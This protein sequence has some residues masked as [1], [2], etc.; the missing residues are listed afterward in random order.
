MFSMLHPLDEIT[1]IVCKSGGLFGSRVQYVSDHTM[2]IVFT[3]ADPSIVMTYDTV[4]G[5]HTVWAL[6]KVKTEEQNAVL[7]YTDQLGTPQHG[8]MNSSLTAH[9]RSVSKGD[10]PAASP[11]QNYS[12]LHSQSRSLS[13]PSIHSRS[14]SPSISNMAA[15]STIDSMVLYM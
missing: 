13:S 1:P 15:L 3:S 6:R 7:K 9:L 11:F 12:S 2:R 8:L 14:H 10:S 4:Q 5:S